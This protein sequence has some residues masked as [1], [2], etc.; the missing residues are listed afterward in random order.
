MRIRILQVPYDS[1][2]RA[3]RMGRGP[4]HLVERGLA[5]RLRDQEH[6]VDVELVETGETF[7]SEIKTTFDLQHR[8]A[9]R[10]R[11]A[12]AAGWFPVVLSGNCNCAIGAMSGLDPRRTGLIWFDA[13]GEFN[14]PETTVGGFLDGMG[15]AIGTGRAWRGMAAHIPGF[16]PIPDSNVVL[17]GGRDFDAEELRELQRTAITLVSPDFVTKW[18]TL[19]ALMP[20]LSALHGRIADVYVHLDLDVLDPSEA[21]ANLWAVPGGLTIAQVDQTL[22]LIR[23]RFS[24]RGIGLGSFDPD[25]DRDGR[26]LIAAFRLIDTL[27]SPLP[28]GSESIKVPPTIQ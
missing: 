12:V 10:V 23:R 7:P 22:R 13:H 28:D 2:Q 17:I 24:L 11:A 5:E 21:T 20:T 26:A 9:D 4:L 6:E 25:A 19:G 18:G 8:L 14:T 16:H 3:L 15:L 27:C 1:G